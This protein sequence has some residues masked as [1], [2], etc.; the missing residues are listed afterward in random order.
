MLFYFSIFIV[1]EQECFFQN[2]FKRVQTSFKTDVFEVEDDEHSPFGVTP[3][4]VKVLVGGD[5]PL[6]IRELAPSA[7]RPDPSLLLLDLR[8][9]YFLIVIGEIFQVVIYVRIF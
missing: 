4:V 5:Y 9:H 8:L 2:T 7:V 3:Q 1:I 6:Q